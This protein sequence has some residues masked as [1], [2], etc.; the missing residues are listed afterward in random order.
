[1]WKARDDRWP[2]WRVAESAVREQVDA[3][4]PGQPV[5]VPGAARALIFLRPVLPEDVLPYR[6]FKNNEE[7]EADAVRESSKPFAQEKKV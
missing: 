2:R 1:M 5:V 4:V 6:H 7:R 3:S